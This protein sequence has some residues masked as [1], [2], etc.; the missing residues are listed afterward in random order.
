MQCYVVQLPDA[1]RIN[2]AIEQQYLAVRDAPDIEKSHY[3]EG[4]YENIYVPRERMPA[5]RPVLEAARRGA[6]E[7]LDRPVSG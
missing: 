2:A 7:F 5:L 3:F 1:D 4:R 6:A